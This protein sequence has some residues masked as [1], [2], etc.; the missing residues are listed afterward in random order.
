MK[1]EFSALPE[2]IE[3]L[4]FHPA[5]NDLHLETDTC[6]FA[7]PVA[8]RLSV[9]KTLD[10]LVVEG[11]ARTHATATCVRC[12]DEFPVSLD[13]SFRVIARVVPDDEAGDDTGDENFFLLRQSE[14]V[15]DLTEIVHDFLLL[16]LPDNPLCR[17]ECAGLCAGCG[18]NLN[19]EPCVCAGKPAS[20]PLAQLSVLLQ[21]SDRRG[22]GNP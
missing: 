4:E 9:N 11:L 10:Q 6:T 7:G 3:T 21:P 13:E 22:N 1:I 5:P 17:E 14:P 18:R 16:A 20:G 12:L 15:W 19:R 8:V 2:G